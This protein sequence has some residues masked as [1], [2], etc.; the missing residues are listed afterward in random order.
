MILVSVIYFL[1][2]P[3]RCCFFILLQQQKQIKKQTK[4]EFLGKI[5]TKINFLLQNICTYRKIFVLL[6]RKIK[7]KTKRNEK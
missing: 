5:K 1:A 6:Q 4:T 2:A 3:S 7:K